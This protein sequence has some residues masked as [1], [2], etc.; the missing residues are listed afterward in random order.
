[1]RILVAN[2]DGPGS[3]LEALVKAVIGSGHE[4]FLAVPE[5]P[6][7][8]VGKAVS[9]RLTYRRG[10]LYGVP[11]VLVDT[12]PADAV[13]VVLDGVGRG[14]DL[15]VSGVNMGPNLGA[16]DVYS[17]GTLGAVFEAALRGFRGMAVSL[18]A[19]S[20]R[21]Y[22]DMP[23]AKYRAAAELAMRLLDMLPPPGEWEAPV[24]N[25][26]V[27]A[28]G[29]RGLRVTSVEKGEVERLLRCRDGECSFEEWSLSSYRCLTPGSDVCAVLEGYAS[30]SPI[31]LSPT[32]GYG[33]LAE[34]LGGE[35]LYIGEG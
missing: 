35:T 26:N 10:E 3:G 34:A 27:P 14:F 28:W 20:W 32:D 9:F 4:A 30:L 2:D 29:W 6:R 5:K 15:V 19:R 24:L 11:A 7:S 12:T 21:D 1:V 16:W 25:L 18:V 31:G 23:A 8:G 33:W 22:R 13:A 17:S